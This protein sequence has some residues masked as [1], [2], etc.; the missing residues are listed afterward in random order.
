MFLHV[1]WSVKDG[2]ISGEVVKGPKRDRRATI[3]ETQHAIRDCDVWKCREIE[4][5]EE[6]LVEP[7][8]FLYC[9]FPTRFDEFIMAYPDVCEIV[10][11]DNE[12][13]KDLVKRAARQIIL[14]REPMR[15]TKSVDF[16]HPIGSTQIIPTPTI[17]LDDVAW[18]AR[19]VFSRKLRRV[20]P[21][22]HPAP[23]SVLSLDLRPVTDAR[24][25]RR[26]YALLGTHYGFPAPPEP[27]YASRSE[28]SESLRFWLSHA[29]SNSKKLF[30]ET[31]FES[32]FR[33]A[34][35]NA[36]SNVD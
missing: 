33:D 29:Y 9:R 15:V 6:I 16:G 34:Y 2:K 31:C 11:E 25:P 30:M 1:L 26:I 35:L 36:G 5:S 8:K 20:H 7:L 17:G 28:S 22:T 24:A 3:K 13:L 12:P 32:T 14:P 10:F 19:N 4:D 23:T 27:W 18:F 21:D